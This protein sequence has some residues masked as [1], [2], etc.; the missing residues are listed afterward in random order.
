MSSLARTPL[1]PA[2][3]APDAQRALA[4]PQ[5]KMM[6]ARGL[7]PVARPRDLLSLLY[8][9]AID[10][11]D[12]LRSAAVT[13]A[14]GLPDPVV[15][16]GLVD[17][18]L[19]P[20]VLDLFADLLAAA[21]AAVE[22][23]IGNPSTADETMATIAGRGSAAD[24]DLI[25]TN[26]QRLLRAPAI[27]AAMYQN[28]NARMSTVDRV[29]ELAVRNGVKVPGIPAWEEIQKI[30]AAGGERDDQQPAADVD[31]Q[32]ARAAGV[33]AGKAAEGDP[34]TPSE[35]EAKEIWALSAPMKIRLATLG[36]AFDRAI[37]IRDPK[38][39]VAMAAIKSP[40]MTD[41]EVM[42]Y[43][44]MSTLAEEVIG[45][46]AN[47]R[48]WTKM[49]S[50]KLSLVN[51]PKCPVGLAMRLLPHLREKDQDNLARSKGIPSALAA[52]ARKLV[53]QRQTGRR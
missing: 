34:G 21:P 46:I 47:Q 40:G 12:K 49:Y 52:Q 3:L 11:D 8:Q 16:G 45:Y 1:D 2:Q 19:D 32:F 53:M 50:V 13:S 31:A 35:T 36:N 24:V 18:G 20:R 42:R 26:E 37:L 48:E 10:A 44:G 7:V 28:R 51:N 17:P 41:P 22:R 6:A 25:A 43:A 4:S 9:L 33:N 23:I 30:Y 27:I 39:I 29:V 15:R 14:R 38:K 5:S